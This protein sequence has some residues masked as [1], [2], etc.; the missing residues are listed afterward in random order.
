MRVR[1]V[2]SIFHATKSGTKEQR[3][4]DSF[5]LKVWY[6]CFIFVQSTHFSFLFWVLRHWFVFG[7]RLSSD[8]GWLSVTIF[9]ASP[10]TNGIHSEN[11]HRRV[12]WV[13]W[14]RTRRPVQTVFEASTHHNV[15]FLIAT[16]TQRSSDLLI[17]R[18]LGS[19]GTRE[20]K[21]RT[22]C[23]SQVLE[24]VLLSQ[25]SG[26]LCLHGVQIFFLATT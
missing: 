26:G 16:A 9:Q 19:T 12:S 8:S 18:F 13:S 17:R 20:S 1:L 25:V 15:L 22:H 7:P 5:G 11:V 21:C 4:P 3:W 23:F 14:V 10:P 2:L 24:R 6:I